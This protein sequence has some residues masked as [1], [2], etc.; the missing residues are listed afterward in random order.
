MISPVLA[1]ESPH[2]AGHTVLF[3]S[4]YDPCD[5]VSWIQMTRVLD[6]RI[7]ISICENFIVLSKPTQSSR[8][9]EEAL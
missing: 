8:E 6:T 5:S 7:G 1:N 9:V 2:I 4:T 3:R